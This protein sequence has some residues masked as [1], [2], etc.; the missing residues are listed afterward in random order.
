MKIHIIC[1]T[2]VLSLLVFVGCDAED[3]ETTVAVKQETRHDQ[4]T[5]SGSSEEGRIDESDSAGAEEEFFFSY[6]MD[7]FLEEIMADT[8]GSN[9]DHPSS[10]DINGTTD[11]KASQI[12]YPVLLSEDFDFYMAENLESQYIYYYAPHD[13]FG[14]NQINFIDYKVAIVLYISKGGITFESATAQCGLTPN[15]G[16]A[17][18]E[19][20]NF[21]HIDYDGTW[22][23]VRFPENVVLDDP[24]F[25]SDYFLF[26]EYKPA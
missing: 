18:D 8:A 3:P 22:I 12:L 15:D 7:T 5:T 4:N 16:F 26:E 11:S 19:T 23:G 14:S 9:S 20:D 17:Y 25:I 21:W 2:V 13:G 6:E 1:L 10:N 24:E